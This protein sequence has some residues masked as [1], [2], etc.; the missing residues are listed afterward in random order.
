MR[1]RVLAITF[2]AAAL[3]PT[4]ASAQ[5]PAPP[6]AEATT[7]DV[8]VS[9]SAPPALTPG[10]A[11]S[12]AEE[13]LAT[14]RQ[15]LPM[16]LSRPLIVPQQEAP[17]IVVSRIEPRRSQDG[18]VASP[19]VDEALPQDPPAPAQTP[20]LSL[21]EEV[22]RALDGGGSAAEGSGEPSEAGDAA[23]AAGPPAPTAPQ[24]APTEVSAP[25]TP[26]APATTEAQGVD[27][28]VSAIPL[29]PTGA[30]GTA[31][32]IPDELLRAANSAGPEPLRLS[33][34]AFG[35]YQRG[36]YGTAFDV[37]LRASAADDAAA[38]ALIG[39]L[40]EEAKGV[41]QDLAK[42]AGWY[43]V[44]A[45]LGS[46]SAKFRLAAMLLRG[47]GVPKDEAKAADVFEA[48]ANAGNG[49]AA[50]A[51]ALMLLKGEG[52]EESEEE[53]FG[54][55]VLAAER[56]DPGA[57]YALALMYEDGQGTEVDE[58]ASTRWFGRAASSGD[59]AAALAYGERMMLGIGADPDPDAA[60]P[61]LAHAARYGEARA[62]NLYARLLVDRAS[63]DAQTIEAIKWHLLARHA[64]VSDL[65]IDGFMGTRPPEIVDAAREK[66]AAFIR[67]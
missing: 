36:L 31:P 9:S 54:F 58:A 5:A 64:G 49:Q 30:D 6:A 56:G 42:A 65:Y 17:G 43:A 19:P 39:R 34:Y 28:A 66:A 61:F 55:M 10:P 16:P 53:A 40:Y 41:D 35:A 59:P 8:N 27:A 60:A 67:R 47:R 4:G 1:T 18:L 57:Q 37:A 51:L 21:A 33:H 24:V 26:P 23:P 45:D 22:R 14:P 2:V 46:A 48:A 12:L 50:Y 29:M 20:P 25:P 62:M 38:A 13:M 44:A 7:D 52:R 15:Y 32:S 63:T 11:P 3:M